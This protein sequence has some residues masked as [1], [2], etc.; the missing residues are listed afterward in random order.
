MCTVGGRIGWI[1]TRSGTAR[2]SGIPGTT[3]MEVNSWKR[4][5]SSNCKFCSYQKVNVSCRTPSH[6][7]W[8]SPQEIPEHLVKWRFQGLPNA[9]IVRREMEL[10]VLVPLHFSLFSSLFSTE[11]K[12]EMCLVFTSV[13][14]RHI[15]R[16]NANISYT[17]LSLVMIQN[18]N[19]RAP[20]Q[21]LAK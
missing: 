10:Q 9:P 6:K 19:L 20:P 12:C 16:S 21:Q 13:I 7:I 4:R 3:T 2:R 5:S 1:V 8:R 17:C 15:H 14:S 18:F 11:M